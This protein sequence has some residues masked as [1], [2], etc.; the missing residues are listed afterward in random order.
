MKSIFVLTLVL[1]AVM[2]NVVSAQVDIKRIPKEEPKKTSFQK[3]SER[4]KIGYFGVFTTPNLR[5]LKNGRF[6]NGATSPEFGNAP[7]GK[8]K[9]QDTWPMNLWNQVAFAYDFGAKMKFAVIPRF[10][11]PLAPNPSMKKPEDRSQVMLDDVLVGFAGV[12]AAS[13]DKK[14][15]LWIRPGMRLPTSHASRN[16]GNGG[17]GAT[18][19]QLELAFNPTYDFNKTWQLGMF[20]QF[21]YWV[22]EDQYGID[23]LRTI[24]N[25]YIQYTFNDVSRLQVYYE[26]ILESDTRGEAEEDR[27]ILFTDRWQNVS[28]IYSYDITPKFNFSPLVGVFVNDTPITDRSVWAGA[29]ISY[30]IK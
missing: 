27:K 10:V 6:K 24:T 5:D 23:R 7:K 15:N 12:V 1:T 25:P 21:R 30:Q 13:E 29:W 3:F 16:T 8:G 2:A 14:F 26:L 11:I 19:H 18:T 28:V 22:I 9:N 20:G 17:T 4:L